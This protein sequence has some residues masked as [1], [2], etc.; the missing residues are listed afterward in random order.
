MFRQIAN[1]SGKRSPLQIA[2]MGLALIILFFAGF[3]LTGLIFRP[4][5]PATEAISTPQ[6]QSGGV[7]VVSPPKQLRDFTLTGKTGAPI[8][9][10]ALR[11]RAVVLFFGYTHCPDECPL[12][13]VNFK[14]VKDLLGAQADQVA[15]VFVSVDGQRDT[16]EQVTRFLDSFDKDF[17]GMTG[18]ADQ[19]RAIGTEYG[20]VFSTENI[21]TPV[22]SDDEHEDT[23]HDHAL[24][25]E[26]YFV[27]HTSPSFLIDRKG[28]L[29]M[30]AFYGTLPATLADRVRQLVDEPIQ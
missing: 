21:A 17:V 5:E 18:S 26:N 11:G 14:R 27:Q 7:G 22:S 25:S 20:L 28:F 9:L 16:P 4:A 1:P 12:T 2:L 23:S 30:V 3:Q 24:D 8:S 29:R 10:S 13:M 15:F 6:A 19:L